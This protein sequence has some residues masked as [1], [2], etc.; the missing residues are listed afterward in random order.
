MQFA[1]TCSAMHNFT[2]KQFCTFGGG[3]GIELI[4]GGSS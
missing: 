1:C 3:D 2:W 4:S